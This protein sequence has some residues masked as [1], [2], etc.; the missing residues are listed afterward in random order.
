LFGIDVARS[1]RA[2]APV[3][4]SPG[5]QTDF[6][7][8]FGPIIALVENRWRVTR[9]IDSP[10]TDARKEPSRSEEARMRAILRLGYVENRFDER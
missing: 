9:H 3:G 4:R 8:D 6:K 10:S 1:A 5:G 2:L 7:A